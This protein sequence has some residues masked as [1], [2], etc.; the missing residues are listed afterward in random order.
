[1]EVEPVQLRAWLTG[2]E[3]RRT[4][5]GHPHTDSRAD[6][7]RRLRDPQSSHPDRGSEQ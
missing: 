7:E 1:V 4:S 6:L 5:Q 3:Q 2:A